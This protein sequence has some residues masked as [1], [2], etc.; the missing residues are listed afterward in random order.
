MRIITTLML[1]VSLSLSFYGQDNDSEEKLNYLL[2]EAAWS[3]DIDSV[4]YYI[5]AGADVNARNKG[6]EETALMYAAQEGHLDVV[7][8]LLKNE[9]KPDLIPENNETALIRATALGYIDIVEELIRAGANINQS[10]KKSQKPLHYAAKFGY[11]YIADML[12]YYEA[13]VNA[14]ARYDVTPLMT[15]IISGYPA[16]AELLIK[17]GADINA[18]DSEGFTPLMLASKYAFHKLAGMML[19]KGATIDKTTESGNTA[20]TLAIP[21]ANYAIVDT[22]LQNGAHVN[23]RLNNNLTPLSLARSTA[24]DSIITLLKENDASQNIIP[25]FDYSVIRYSISGN[26]DDAL[27]GIHYGYHEAKSNINLTLGIS[28]RYFAKR[29]LEKKSPTKIHQYWERRYLLPLT[30]DYLLNIS[31]EKQN[32]LALIA[33]IKG[34]YTW[35]RYRGVNPKPDDSFGWNPRVGFLWKPLDKFGITAHYEYFDL[36]QKTVS[37]HRVVLGFNLFLPRTLSLEDTS[38]AAYLIEN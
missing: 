18:T 24:N 14:K 35:G 17:S 28:M 15:S 12:I 20:L 38:D 10:G 36:K 27:F 2:M 25:Y 3:G 32:Q 33:G 16:I 4:A 8:L 9:A 26:T 11:Y 7:R 19:Q 5:D 13:N 1:V 23:H 6:S 30:L 31:S 22:L 37:P 21:T 29:V 34:Y